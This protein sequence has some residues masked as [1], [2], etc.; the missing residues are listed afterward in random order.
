MPLRKNAARSTVAIVPRTEICT[1]HEQ[2][3]K[4]RARHK[5]AL[6][7]RTGEGLMHAKNPNAIC[8]Q[9][10]SANAAHEQGMEG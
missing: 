7:A 10:V 4:H 8:D 2:L 5:Q 6:R 9:V 3:L 1:N